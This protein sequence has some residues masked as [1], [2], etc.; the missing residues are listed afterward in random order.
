MQG[1]SEMGESCKNLVEKF[2]HR[3]WNNKEEEVAFYIMDEYVTFRGSLGFQA[4]GIQEFLDY[5]RS[6]HRA[7][8]NYTCRIEDIVEEKE[9]TAV[10]LTFKGYHQGRFFGVDGTGR[11]IQWAGVAFF[12]I[13]NGKICDVWVLGDVSDIKRQLGFDENGRP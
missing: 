11:E 3:I 7:L 1:D 9:K 12:H 10:K 5:L 4:R 8:G 2:Y 6:V 13:S